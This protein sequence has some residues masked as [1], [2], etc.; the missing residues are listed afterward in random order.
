MTNTWTDSMTIELKQHGYNDATVASLQI[1]HIE[2]DYKIYYRGIPGQRKWY[3]L[4]DNLIVPMKLIWYTLTDRH[5][6]KEYWRLQQVFKEMRA[7][8]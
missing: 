4:I 8:I 1:G 6:R 5:F 3:Q 7:G 2:C